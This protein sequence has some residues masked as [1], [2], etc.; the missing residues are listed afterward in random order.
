MSSMNKYTIGELIPNISRHM[1]ANHTVWLQWECQGCHEKITADNAIAE[2]FEKGEKCI[3]LYK[4]YLHSVKD[5]GS[6]C[7]VSTPITAKA[8]NF[9][10]A[11]ELR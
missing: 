1:D 3:A 6:V 2:V 7:G 8:F 11:M 9:M 10:V 4:N 5:D